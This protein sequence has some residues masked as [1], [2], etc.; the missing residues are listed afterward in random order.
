MEERSFRNE[1][2]Y[3]TADLDF[4]DTGQYIFLYVL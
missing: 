2:D 1:K 3:V 4:S